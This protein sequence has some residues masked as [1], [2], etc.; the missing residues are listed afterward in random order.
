VVPPLQNAWGAGGI[1]SPRDEELGEVC[2]D[3]LP[4]LPVRGLLVTPCVGV[5][6]VAAVAVL[7]VCWRLGASAT[8]VAVPPVGDGE[9]QRAAIASVPSRVL[10]AA[11]HASR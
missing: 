6:G 9:G 2:G 1:A 3:P 4:L 11:L 10:A 5:S 7:S 8:A